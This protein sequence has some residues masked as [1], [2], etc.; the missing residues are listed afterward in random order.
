MIEG[1]LKQA[2]GRLK[3]ARIGVSIE[4]KGNR[5]Y[6]RSTFPPRPNSQKEQSYQQ[7]LA[8]GYHANPAGLKLAEKEARRVGVLLDSG[9]FD[10]AEFIHCPQPGTVA[11][12]L[13][14]FESDYFQ[15]RS[16][17][18]KSE[19]TWRYDYRKVFDQLPPDEPLTASLLLEVVNRK[20]ADT[21]TRKRFVDVLQRLAAFA[22][23]EI[24]L[25]PLR[26]K[27]SNSKVKPRE[28]PSD[29][30]IAQAF[31]LIPNPAWRRVFGLIATYGLRP[32]EVFSLDFDRWPVLLVHDDT[33]TGA[34][35]SRPLYPEWAEEWKL[36]QG[37]MPRCSGRNNVELGSRVT[38][39]F[40][41]YQVGFAPYDLRHAWAVR[42][43]RFG[44]P[45]SIAC[46]WMGNSVEIFTKTYQ[47]WIPDDV[48]D[49]VFAA[50]VERGDR[51]LPPLLTVT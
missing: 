9:Q 35:R 16:R 41:R 50:L 30:A 25:K 6:L 15:R 43:I 8:L 28:L 5:L 18:P 44:I 47:A 46:R 31:S 36:D 51:P 7:R 4:V 1:R 10:W 37:E 22:E 11:E 33:K 21:R 39:A 34:R 20:P 23:I 45:D 13:E 40:A 27:Y 49:I 32:H 14:K 19:V 17:T 2:N 38:H 42:T 12:W 29:E 3:A 24:D 48:E 26:G